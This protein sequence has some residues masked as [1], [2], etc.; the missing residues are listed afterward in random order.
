MLLDNLNF[1]ID[2]IN[3]R[4]KNYNNYS[5]TYNFKPIKILKEKQYLLKV[6]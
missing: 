3:S 5:E 2:N 1:I 4:L 6:L